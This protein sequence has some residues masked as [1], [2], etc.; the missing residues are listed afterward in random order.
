MW[1]PFVEQAPTNSTLVL[2]SDSEPS[3]DGSPTKEEGTDSGEMPL[4]KSPNIADDDDETIDKILGGTNAKSPSSKASR[5]K[6]LKKGPKLEDNSSPGKN[7]MAKSKKRKGKILTYLMT[8][9]P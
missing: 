3:R 1:I 7:K 5:L 6:S 9:S 4:S 8:S 2:S